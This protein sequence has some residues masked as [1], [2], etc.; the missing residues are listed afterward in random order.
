VIF[1]STSGQARRF[2]SLKRVLIVV[3]REASFVN[4]HR[5]VYLLFSLNLVDAIVTIIWVRSGLAPEANHLMAT[6]LDLGVLPFLLVKLG[7]GA[8]ACATLIY[9]SGFR[10]ARIG[11]AVALVVYMGVMLTHVVTGFAALGF[12]S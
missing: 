11:V 7:I 1:E 10:A 3:V 8:A 4:V 2:F 6:L 5:A 9:G 12:L